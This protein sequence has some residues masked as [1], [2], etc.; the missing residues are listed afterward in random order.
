MENTPEFADEAAAVVT[1]KLTTD[2][3]AARPA[4]ENIVTN[5]DWPLAKRRQGTTAR[6][7]TSAP[8]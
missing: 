7:A 6:I 3:A 5:G 2:A 4:S 8:T 1:T